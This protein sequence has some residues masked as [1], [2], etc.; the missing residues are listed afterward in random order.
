MECSILRRIKLPGPVHKTDFKYIYDVSPDRILTKSGMWPLKSMKGTKHVRTDSDHFYKNL[1]ANEYPELDEWVDYISVFRDSSVGCLCFRHE[2]VLM[3]TKNGFFALER[4]EDMTLLR[5]ANS[6]KSLIN[7]GPSGA[8]QCSRISKKSSGQG[9]I[10]DVVSMIHEKGYSSQS[11]HIITNNCSMIT[12]K[13]YKKF[14]R[15]TK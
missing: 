4:F 10:A 7:F 12:W 15:K 2:F 1:K 5:Q 9:T 11:Y 3:K 13:V 8:R 14:R 6:S